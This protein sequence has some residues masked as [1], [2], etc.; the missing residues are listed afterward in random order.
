MVIQRRIS[1]KRYLLAAILTA[2]IFSFG[3]TLGM[4]LDE[5][6]S[7]WAKQINDEQIINYESLQLQY[8]YLSTLEN[9]SCAVMNAALE[10]SVYEL[11]K[12]L[13]DLLGYKE[14]T[15]FEEYDFTLIERNYL[16]SNLKYWLFAEKTKKICQSDMV[17][18]LYFYSDDCLSCPDQGVIL[19]YFKKKLDNKLLVFPINVD[20]EGQEYIIKI[21]KSQ[22]NV[23]NEEL[24]SIIINEKTYK[25][26]VQ[27]E[28]LGEILC[29]LFENSEIC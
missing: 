3:L 5:E 15:S 10:E 29:E 28:E 8:L 18:I 27:K 16:L 14:E 12:A 21:L 11:N 17:T 26:V 24:P 1:W 4:L 6:R 9:E 22:Y 13:N 19:S 2:I 25:G 23:S 7:N 20:L